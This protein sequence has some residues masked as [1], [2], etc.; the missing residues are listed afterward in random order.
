MV[1]ILHPNKQFN[2]VFLIRIVEVRN[3]NY[4]LGTSKIVVKERYVLQK[5]TIARNLY[6]NRVTDIYHAICDTPLT[7]IISN[8]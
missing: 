2:V 6:D 3:I 1:D 8:V 4:P 5:W 7:P